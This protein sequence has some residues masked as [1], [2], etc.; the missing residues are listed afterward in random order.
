MGTVF[1]GVLYRVFKIIIIFNEVDRVAK[2]LERGFS[3]ESCY[4]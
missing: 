1:L 3:Y 2:N 4:S